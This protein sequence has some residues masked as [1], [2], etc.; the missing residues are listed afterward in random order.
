MYCKHVCNHY[1]AGN[2]PYT[3]SYWVVPLTASEHREDWTLSRCHPELYAGDRSAPTPGNRNQLSHLIKH[4]IILPFCHLLNERLFFN[5]KIHSRS[6][7]QRPV[8][9]FSA[10]FMQ[11]KIMSS[12]RYSA[13]RDKPGV[14]LLTVSAAI[15]NTKT[16]QWY[17]QRKNQVTSIK[18]GK[19]GM[20]V[21][22]FNDNLFSSRMHR[23][24][25]G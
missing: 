21:D 9:T 24:L 25:S 10:S 18:N 17:P 6:K 19:T 4:Y 16:P 3:P 12:D 11:S 20:C 15:N 1:R 2:S 8:S 14:G 5:K 7:L 22:V 23:N 13:E